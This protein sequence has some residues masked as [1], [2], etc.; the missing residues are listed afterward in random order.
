MLPPGCRKNF[1][2]GFL[3]LKIRPNSPAG[4]RGLHGIFNDLS[5]FYRC[6]FPCMNPRFA[7][8][9]YNE[10]HWMGRQAW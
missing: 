5:G 9:A 8:W 7:G 6:R 4:Q 2:S 3:G 10:G 1:T